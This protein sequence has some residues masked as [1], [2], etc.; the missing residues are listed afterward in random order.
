MYILHPDEYL[1][2][3]YRIS[4]FRTRDIVLNNSYRENNLI[5]EYFRQ[6]LSDRTYIYTFNGR[7]AINIALSFYKLKK[8]DVV[9]ILTTSGN[10]Y[11]SGCVTREIEKFC[12]WS[13]DF[14][15]ETKLIFV[16]H[17]FGY[18]YPELSSL[19]KYNIPIIEDCAAS[20]FSADPGN[21]I[22]KVGDF[23]IYSLPKMF[24][25]QI[26]GLLVSKSEN[27]DNYNTVLKPELLRY[28]RKVLSEYIP[29]RDQIINIRIKNYR[30]LK[31]RFETLNLPERFELQDGIVPGVFLFRTDRFDINL[32][33][34]RK[35]FWAHGIQ[36][37]VFYG[38]K[39]FYIPVHQAL[40]SDD[41]D[42]FYAVMKTFLK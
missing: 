24:P 41:L 42:Y 36:S 21:S 14:V 17:E 1:F 12:K 26:G 9:T 3:S 35:H 5:D 29:K 6:R 7:T 27:L 22:G 37:S 30:E 38:E 32:A 13:R 20:F 40:V 23:I 25:L 16:N 34:L 19:Q 11:I 4:P 10:F 28:I 15:P 31:A 8:N 2:P 39:A 18:P 33:E